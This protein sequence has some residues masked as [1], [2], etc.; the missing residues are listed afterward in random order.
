MNRLILCSTGLAL[1][2][3]LGACSS[4]KP[5]ITVKADTA[6]STKFERIKA[7]EGI[8]TT[9]DQDGDGTPDQT[10]VYKVVSGGSAVMEHM[11][12]NTPH[13]MI[14]MYSMDGT[15][16]VVTHFCALENT[17]MMAS[18]PVNQGNAVR[19]KFFDGMNVNSEMDQYMGEMSMVFSGE[20]N[21]EQQWT[22]F[23]EGKPVDQVTFAW[24]RSQGF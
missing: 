9:T 21:F 15:K 11:F 2:A 19:F 13:E 4:S 6:T 18:V 24:T 14:T 8:W 12:P 17:S 7:L 10:A 5:V 1:A 20:N 3:T 23:Q 16:L 22:S